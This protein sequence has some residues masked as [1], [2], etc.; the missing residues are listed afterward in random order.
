MRFNETNDCA[1]KSLYTG[2]KDFVGQK[3]YTI[4]KIKDDF[5]EYSI[6]IS[7]EISFKRN[8]IHG[9]TV[10]LNKFNPVFEHRFDSLKMYNVCTYEYFNG[11]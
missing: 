1:I 6:N 5:I 8:V 9:G 4:K 10:D 7:N 2:I 3:R 11:I